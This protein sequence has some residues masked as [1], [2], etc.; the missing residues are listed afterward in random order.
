M[1]ASL[2]L[3]PGMTIDWVASYTDPQ[4]QRQTLR[5]INRLL[6]ADHF[7]VVLKT[8]NEKGPVLE[9]TYTRKK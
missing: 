6:D 7:V 2:P 4:G 3:R 5:I 9:T 8:P 1:L